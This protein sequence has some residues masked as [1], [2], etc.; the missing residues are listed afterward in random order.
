MLLLEELKAT[1]DLTQYKYS[2]L[3]KKEE[4][5]NPVDETKPEYLNFKRLGQEINPVFNR[6][7]KARQQYLKIFSKKI[8]KLDP[9]RGNFLK[10]KLTAEKELLNKEFDKAEELFLSE[11]EEFLNKHTSA[12]KKAQADGEEYIIYDQEKNDKR[13]FLI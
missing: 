11:V 6:A 3:F 1:Q 4:G 13:S 10:N 12:G 9:R 2:S 8:S 7:D 5:F